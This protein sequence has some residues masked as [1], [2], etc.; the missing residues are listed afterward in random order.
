MLVS[1]TFHYPTETLPSS[2]ELCFPPDALAGSRY[3]KPTGPNT[4]LFPLLL[5]EVLR[6]P[7]VELPRCA[8]RATGETQS[9]IMK[10]HASSP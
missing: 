4:P 6:M 1:T 9:I 8:L 2:H 3:Q 10:I 7:G 5:S